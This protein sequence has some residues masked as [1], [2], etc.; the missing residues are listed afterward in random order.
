MSAWLPIS[1][2]PKDGTRILVVRGNGVGIVRW[3]GAPHDIWKTD[4][5]YRIARPTHW[6]PL[7]EPPADGE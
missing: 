2:A 4:G 7:P 3:I 5:D 6:Q 1:T